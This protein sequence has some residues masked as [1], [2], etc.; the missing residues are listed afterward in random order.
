MSR[1]S[2]RLLGAVLVA[3]PFVAILTALAHEAGVMVVLIIS[4]IV[5]L[6]VGTTLLGLFLLIDP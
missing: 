2:R 4:C 1:R 6:F 3:S 5:A